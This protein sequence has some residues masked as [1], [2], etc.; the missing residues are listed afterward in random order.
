MRFL[1]DDSKA[2]AIRT[3]LRASVVVFTAFGLDLDA[4]QVA[5]IQLMTEAVIQFLRSWFGGRA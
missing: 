1:Y 2:S 5:A 3:L 4:N